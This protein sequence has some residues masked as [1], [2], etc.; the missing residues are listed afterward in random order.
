MRV[1]RIERWRDDA[2]LVAT[3]LVSGDELVVGLHGADDS[4]APGNVIAAAVLFDGER[5]SILGW[6]QVDGTIVDGLVSGG[7]S[8]LVRFVVEARLEVAAQTLA[9]LETT[10]AGRL[11]WLFPDADPDERRDLSLAELIEHEH[12]ELVAA[13]ADGRELVRVADGHEISPGMHL[14]VHEIVAEQILGDDPR[15]MWVT[16]VRLGNQGYD[17]HEILHMLASTVSHQVFGMLGK[18]R[19]YDHARHLEELAALPA[20]WEAARDVHRPAASSDV[21]HRGRYRPR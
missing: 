4:L 21:R 15:E 14:A 18:S 13:I 20:T 3:E 1:L 10:R 2:S 8:A 6:V 11:E 7:L 9:Q 12:P 16:A 5:D 19:P 17:R